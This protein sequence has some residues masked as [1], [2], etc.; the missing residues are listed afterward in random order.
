MSLRVERVESVAALEAIET[1]WRELWQRD[2]AATPF[3][4]PEW[5]LP[6]TRHLWD[7]GKL[8]VLAVRNG[9]D[10]VA[11]APLF[12]WGFGSRPEIVRVSFL[13]SG[14]T[15]YL[16]M[17][18]DPAYSMAAARVVLEE[19]ANTAGEWSVCAFEELRP[20]STLLRSEPPPGL[21]VR[22]APSSV[23]PVASVPRSFEQFLAGLPHKFRKNLRQA[24]TR[25][26]QNGA[27]FNTA[28]T[29][30]VPDI[31]RAL[32][33]LHAA[34]W[35]ERSEPGMLASERL[36]QF[37]LD[38][39]GRLAGSGLLR[40]NAIRLDGSVIAA[41][42]NLWRGGRLY[43]YLS[44]FDPAYA[45]YSPGA[46]LLAWSIRSAIAEGAAE[47]DFLRRREEYK[48]QWGARDR[49]NRKLLILP[50]AADARDVA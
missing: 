10:L 5:L 17:T 46:A 40:L 13:G 25:L 21:I 1:E 3:E 44:G 23:C 42:Y 49:A 4:S 33:R 41:Q 28:G 20:G 16:G 48:R 37:H 38:A 22:N 30:E 32:F 14:V 15:D 19:L 9:S 39:A 2:P 24:E 31:M 7:G 47:L 35:S 11:L 12:L 29:S 43:Y 27:E 18:A 34:R 8:R 45:R 6:W 36:Q 50:S 26:R